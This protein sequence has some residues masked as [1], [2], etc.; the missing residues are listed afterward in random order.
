MTKLPI[1]DTPIQHFLRQVIVDNSYVYIDYWSM[2]HF[3]SGLI[4][5]IIFATYFRRKFSWLIVI[6]I[7]IIYEVFEVLLDGTLFVSETLVDKFWDVIIGMIGF[8]ITYI[9]FSLYRK[10]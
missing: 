1:F 5:G 2:V 10:S 4:L 7:I 6:S 9:I 3:S 8:F